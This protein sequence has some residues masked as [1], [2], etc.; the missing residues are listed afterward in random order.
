MILVNEAE[1]ERRLTASDA[2]LAELREHFSNGRRTPAFDYDH[3]RILERH[4]GK[5]GLRVVPLGS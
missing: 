4:L 5:R 3:Y 2:E 1:Y